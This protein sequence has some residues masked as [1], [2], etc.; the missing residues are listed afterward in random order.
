MSLLYADL[1]RTLKLAIHIRKAKK[2][3][4]LSEILLTFL[5]ADTR[6]YTLPCRSVCRYVSPSVRHIFE[7]QAFFSFLLLPNHPRL[8]CR[9]SGRVF[10]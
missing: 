1:K 7:F 3:R 5:V 4:V 10:L 9:V 6:L 8:D 2:I